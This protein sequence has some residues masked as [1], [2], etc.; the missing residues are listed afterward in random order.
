MGKSFRTVDELV[1]ILESRGVKTDGA[2]APAIARESYYAIVNGYKKPFLDQEKMESSNDDVYKE[3]VEFQWMHDLFMF[4]RDLR[5]VT[6][7]YLT[8]AEAVMRTAVAYAFCHK[9]PERDAYLER[10]NFCS[11]DEYLVA[12]TYKGNKRALH[13][14]N[15]N[16]LMRRLN[17]K[18]VVNDRSRDFVK[19]YSRKYGTVPLWVLANDLTFGNIVHFYQLMQTADRREACA[20]I[21]KT[22]GRDR[23][24]GHLTERALLR[25]ASV[26][27]DF[28]NLCAHD[29]RLYC[30]KFG[31]DDF[32]VM[33]ER[34]MDLLPYDEVIEFID[35]IMALFDAYG[36]RLHGV[37]AESLLADMGFEIVT[38][39]E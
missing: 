14:N 16:D 24:R 26:L 27:N 33:V 8:R 30:S 34:M 4:D 38:A 20:I 29:E 31:N 39:S 19:H 25:S 28:R 13:G 22:A 10:S 36:N 11:A 2:T 7:K 6:F 9:H 15:L 1:A 37:T 18:L 32:S 23:K 35:E 21:A 17:E 12:K 5:F 3:G